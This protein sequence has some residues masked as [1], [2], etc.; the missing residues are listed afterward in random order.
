MKRIMFLLPAAGLGVAA[1]AS[2]QTGSAPTKVA[3]IHIQNAILS[4]KDGQKAA[5]ELQTKFGPRKAQLEKLQNEISQLEDQIRKGS[6]TM[7]DEARQKLMRDR[8]QRNTKLQ[9]DTQDAQE[10][11]QQE[12]GKIMQDLGQRIMAVIDKYAKD[13][14][15]ALVLDVSSPQNPVL[16]AANSIDITKEVIDLYDKNAPSS[17]TSTA[18]P[19]STTTAPPASRP[20]T[21]PV[22]RPITPPAGRTAPPPAKTVPPTK[23]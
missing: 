1:L 6:N 11:V 7:S 2:A 9:R 15:F 21:P 14:G 10:E 8:D 17:T 4:T 22:I 23:K 19:P 13:N 3:I 18:A 20:A 16:Y 12:E 5:N